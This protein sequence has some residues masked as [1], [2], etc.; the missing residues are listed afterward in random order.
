[1][2]YPKHLLAFKNF[3]KASMGIPSIV[4]ISRRGQYI[5]EIGGA[6]QLQLLESRAFER[7][8]FGGHKIVD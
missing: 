6:A 1:M 5:L 7:R 4:I 3:R 2:G 8:D